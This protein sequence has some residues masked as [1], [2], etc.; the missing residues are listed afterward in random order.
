MGGF[1]AK[2]GALLQVGRN[3]F[4]V[5]LDDRMRKAVGFPDASRLA[6]LRELYGTLTTA[7]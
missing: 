7:G 2:H 5:V 1:V 4:P 3:T 6:Q